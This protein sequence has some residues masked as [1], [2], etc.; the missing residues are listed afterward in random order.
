MFLDEDKEGLG[1]QAYNH[2]NKYKYRAK[3]NA[4]Q[5]SKQ[6]LFAGRRS[7]TIKMAK[8]EVCS[9]PGGVLTH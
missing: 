6:M 1:G 4:G 2:N 5:K 8:T 7:Q 9:V 3:R